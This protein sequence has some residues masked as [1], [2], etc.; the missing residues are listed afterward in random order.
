[1]VPWPLEAVLE[2]L[3]IHHGGSSVQPRSYPFRPNRL[4]LQLRRSLGRSLE[5]VTW[6]IWDDIK[7]DRLRQRVNAVPQDVPAPVLELPIPFAHHSA[8]AV[9]SVGL[10]PC[11][12]VILL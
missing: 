7:N 11:P 2:R 4:K 5:T 3:A 8:E 9:R 6:E 12:S 1:M 10:Q